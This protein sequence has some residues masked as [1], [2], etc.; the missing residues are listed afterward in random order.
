MN[1]L[2]APEHVLFMIPAF[3][4]ERNIGE[5]VGALRAEMP[6]ATILV[7]DDGS[8]DSTSQAARGAGAVVVRLPFN[9]GI[10]VTVQTGII[11]ALEHGFGYM[12]RLDGDGQHDPQDIRHFFD[13][14]RERE[15]DLLIG[16]RFIRGEGFRSSLPRRL[17][18]GFLNRMIGLLTGFRVTDATSGYR[19]YSRR[20]MEKFRWFYPDDY[21]EPESII[22]LHNWKMQVAE[23]PVTMK[24]RPTGSSSITFLRSIYYMI[25][26]TMAIL[27]D[28]IRY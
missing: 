3:N 14:L 5:V 6:G 4:E 16:S 13:F 21:P 20:A 25:K 1:E 7:V 11:Y 28:R 2:F 8:R 9:L 23:V 15:V 10:G 26:V 24:A 19:V 18:I 12:L 22:M 17:A 27:L